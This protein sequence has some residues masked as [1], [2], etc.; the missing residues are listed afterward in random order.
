MRKHFVEALEHALTQLEK[1]SR[2]T[3]EDKLAIQE[4]FRYI[5]EMND[6]A[7]TEILYVE[8]Q[9]KKYERLWWCCMGGE[10]S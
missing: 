8:E 6:R 9:L 2:Y 5:M 1:D 10:E 7:D 4:L 3:A